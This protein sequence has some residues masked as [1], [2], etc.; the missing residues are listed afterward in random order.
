MLLILTLMVPLPP[1]RVLLITLGRLPRSCL[2]RANLFFLHQLSLGPDALLLS[3]VRMEELAEAIPHAVG[4][5]ADVVGAVTP[6]EAPKA[7]P[8]IVLVLALVNVARGE[9]RATKALHLA[10]LV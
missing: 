5:H 6:D 1:N 2:G 4:P 3:A 8:L 7:V 9:D 10:L